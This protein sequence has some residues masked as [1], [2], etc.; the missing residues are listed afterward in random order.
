[1]VSLYSPSWPGIW[2]WILEPMW[3]DNLHL[4]SPGVKGWRCWPQHPASKMGSTLNLELIHWPVSSR[5][6]P[7]PQLH[8]K[9]QHRDCSH[10]QI[11]LL[12]GFSGVQTQVLMFT[13]QAPLWAEPCP[14]PVAVMGLSGTS[15]IDP[16]SLDQDQICSS[17]RK[18]NA[19]RQ[20]DFL[21]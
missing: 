4:L 5:E 20:L 2:L 9:P 19:R 11:Q 7:V 18:G 13:R 6:L 1:M 16:Q 17:S 12:C 10:H 15:G 8:P 3:T 21:Q 14:Q